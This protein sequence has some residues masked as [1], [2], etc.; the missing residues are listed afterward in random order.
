MSLIE[1]REGDSAT[2]SSNS[3]KNLPVL[4]N[5][6]HADRVGR[7]DDACCSIASESIWVSHSAES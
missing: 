2:V 7:L 5:P 1:E 4:A 6:L 3:P